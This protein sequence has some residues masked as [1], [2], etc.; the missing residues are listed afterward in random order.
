MFLKM[1]DFRTHYNNLNMKAL[2]NWQSAL[3][4]K[5][6]ELEEIWQTVFKLMKEICK[7]VEQFSFKSDWSAEYRKNRPLKDPFIKPVYLVKWK[8]GRKIIFLRLPITALYQ[9]DPTSIAI[10]L[11]SKENRSILNLATF[12][13]R[14]IRL[15]P[16]LGTM[17]SAYC[18]V[19]STNASCMGFT[20][21]RYCF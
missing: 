9:S 5:E 13:S 10:A 15:S 3:L 8:R 4:E 18:F 21:A 11:S 14:A 6:Q 1:T 17:T 16:P 19:G 20:V 2:S 7:I 12:I